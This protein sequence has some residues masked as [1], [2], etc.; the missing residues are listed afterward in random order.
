MSLRKR[1]EVTLEEMRYRV[2]GVK[3]RFFDVHGKI[4]AI[5]AVICF[6]CVS[7]ALA[8]VSVKQSNEATAKPTCYFFVRLDDPEDVFEHA[9]RLE[10]KMI[11]R[12]VLYDDVFV[13]ENENEFDFSSLNEPTQSRLE[14]YVFKRDFNFIVII[15]AGENNSKEYD[16]YDISLLAKES[17]SWDDVWEIIKTLYGI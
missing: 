1:D 4:I 8:L 5:C 11:C 2:P 14:S 3:N 15:S 16:K 7:F 6:V 10:N 9:A 13:S 12:F 17:L